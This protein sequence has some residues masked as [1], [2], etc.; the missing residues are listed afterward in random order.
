MTNISQQHI[1]IRRK[2]DKQTQQRQH[3]DNVV[4]I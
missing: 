3:Q 2:K 4:D 1:T